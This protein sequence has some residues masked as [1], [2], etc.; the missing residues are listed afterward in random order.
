MCTIH[1]R[2]VCIICVQSIQK[3]DSILYIKSILEVVCVIF[4]QSISVVDIILYIV[5]AGS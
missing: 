2:S 1:A 4:V 5:H 3:V